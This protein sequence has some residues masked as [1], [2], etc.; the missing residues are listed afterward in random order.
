MVWR[1][2]R[3]QVARMRRESPGQL[4]APPT[5]TYTYSLAVLSAL[6][7]SVPVLQSWGNWIVQAAFSASFMFLSAY[8]FWRAE[9]SECPI[10]RKS[11][12]AYGRSQNG[13][14]A[15]RPRKGDCEGLASLRS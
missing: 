9:N 11:C 15:Q 4:V 2:T 12:P 13:F 8:L 1:Q 5:R 14:R 10:G 6:L 7:T 3:K